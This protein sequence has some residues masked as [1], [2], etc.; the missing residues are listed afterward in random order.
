MSHSSRHEKDQRE[1]LLMALKLGPTVKSS[2][3]NANRSQPDSSATPTIDSPIPVD[4][5]FHPQPPFYNIPLNQTYSDS[6]NLP[7]V[8][9]TSQ[10]N[11][12][13][14][15]MAR[16][17]MHPS[18]GKYRIFRDWGIP[19]WFVISQTILF[20]L[21]FVPGLSSL[22]F[23][24]RV[25]SFVL[26]LF[27]LYL[28]WRKG[29]LDNSTQ[30][31][32]TNKWLIAIVS[33]LALMLLHPQTN[34]PVS[35]IAHIL[36]YVSNYSVAFWAIAALRYGYQ[37]QR[38]FILLFLVNCLS[39]LVGIGQFYYP[40]IFLP[41]TISQLEQGGISAL[42][43]FYS[44]D[45]GTQVMRPCGMSDTPGLASYS[46]A[47]AATMGIVI[48]TSYLP[49][50]QRLLGLGLA[51][52]SA[53][54]IY[55]TQVRTAILMVVV[56]LLSLCFIMILQKRWAGVVQL[57]TASF[58]VVI[59]GFFWAASEGGK[60]ISDRYFT[61]IE[62]SPTNVLLNSSRA[63]MV[64]NS[65]SNQIFDMPFGGGLGRYGQ[66]YFYFANYSYGDMIWVEN[67][68]SAWITDGGL[69]MLTLGFGA[70]VFTLLDSLRIA[71]TSP[72]MAIRHWAAG[73]FA[74]NTSVCFSCFGQM[75]FLTNSGQQFWLLAAM[76]HA[77]DRW[78]RIQMRKKTIPRIA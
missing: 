7:P 54:V 5:S 46:G 52:P 19:E 30:D 14:P 64:Q 77:A 70:L 38:V 73:A 33:T 32:T 31:F 66:V 50:W 58:I 1:T 36:L 67:Q 28:V 12:G 43:P 76:A 57:A 3:K 26:S 13:M 49:V 27:F 68:I 65:V 75:P 22:R 9:Y 17:R 29:S 39:A 72:N 23:F 40:N 2:G 48:A 11:P 69:V 74:I 8:Q 34:S 21:M 20:G 10:L 62:D 41:P 42:I 15:G 59:G 44:L 78:T 51:L 61:L 53:T 6:T 35:G 24:S 37:F 60:S 47:M 25:A 4:D 71:T 16:G 45:D 18:S 63:H 55:L 56:S